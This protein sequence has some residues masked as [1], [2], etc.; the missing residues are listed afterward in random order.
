MIYGKGTVHTLHNKTY[1]LPLN[2]HIVRLYQ[3][4]DLKI[5]V[6][7]KDSILQ[8]L[9]INYSDFIMIADLNQNH[10][11]YNSLDTEKFY[12][13]NH[14][15][16]QSI[17]L[18]GYP[19]TDCKITTIIFDTSDSAN[20]PGMVIINIIKTT[21]PDIQTCITIHIQNIYRV[22]SKG[23]LI[24]KHGAITLANLMM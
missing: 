20:A 6:E 7:L 8:H 9:S 14:Q 15:S 11:Y 24:N 10:F 17:N 4:D 23:A 19:L 3:V 22:N 12:Q 21:D 1:T 16:N 13:I 5:N 18:A 2:Q